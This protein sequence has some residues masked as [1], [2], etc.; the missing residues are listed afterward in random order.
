MAGFSAHPT[1]ILL[2]C[3]VGVPPAPG[4]L[5]ASK[6]L[7]QMNNIKRIIGYTRISRKS[8]AGSLEQ[9][10]ER[11]KAAGA[12]EIYYDVASRSNNHRSGLNQV[13]ALIGNKQVDEALFIRIDRMTDSPSVLEKAIKLCLESRVVVRGLDD[14][15]DFTTV[16]GRLHARIL[17]DLARAEVERLSERVKYGWEHVRQ[18]RKAVSPPFG[19]RVLDGRHQLD[20]KPFLCLLD[21]REE[22]SKAEMARE[23]IDLFFELRSLQ[24]AIK[25][26]N[27]KYG[28][29]RRANTPH[30]TKRSNF[31]WCRAG[32]ARW[33]RNPVLCG[34]LVYFPNSEA[35]L[36]TWDAHPDQRLIS[37]EE[38]LEIKKILE[39]NYK[40]RGWG[41]YSP[42][43]PL[44]GLII[45]AECGHR[46]YCQKSGSKNRPIYY[47][48][49]NYRLRAC[50]VKKTIRASV[51]E[52]AVVEALVARSDEI[53][54]LAEVVEENPE[55][56]EVQSLRNQLAGLKALG[57]NPAI[58]TAIAQIEEQIARLLRQ[59]T[60][61]VNVDSTLIDKVLSNRSY[62][63][64]LPDKEKRQLYHDLVEKI[65]VK[66]GVVA[67]IILKV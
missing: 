50:G 2:L 7:K 64:T 29:Q 56:L 14:N 18:Q 63:L 35:P 19:Y 51:V 55:P 37:D 47:Q 34:H 39:S 4:T 27:Q 10:I 57:K 11:L 38:H 9:H 23:L 43:Y 60:Q 61:K 17:C 21:S 44:S 36:I 40:L 45:C 52:Q 3:G 59:H 48:C 28:L 22:L 24:G 25:R 67:Q 54:R 49:S 41:V 26:F 31:Y 58:D 1:R 8:Q 20:Q 6:A 30:S 13:L 16:G 15:I 5:F 12:T 33:L 32:L 65:V 53:A 42:L 66:E 62:W 46:C